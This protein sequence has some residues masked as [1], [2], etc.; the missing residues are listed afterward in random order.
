MNEGRPRHGRR[1][2][3]RP[4]C[5][6]APCPR[7]SG[8]RNEPPASI[9]TA[10]AGSGWSR[11]RLIPSRAFP[12]AANLSLVVLGKALSPGGRSA[13]RRSRFFDNASSL[14]KTGVHFLA[15]LAQGQ[16]PIGTYPASRCAFVLDGCHWG[17]FRDHGRKVACEGSSTEST[18]PAKHADGNRPFGF[19][20]GIELV[21]FTPTGSSPRGENAGVRQTLT[22]R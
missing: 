20:G 13:D 4:H 16:N 6:R 15:S 19:V 5:R 3:D 8:P 11:T 22:Q 21:E 1:S 2:A 17:L 14:R 9:G 10:D 12:R 7:R 18:Q